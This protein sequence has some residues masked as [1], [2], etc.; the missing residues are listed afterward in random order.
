MQPAG[1]DHDPPDSTWQHE[2]HNGLRFKY[3]SLR[4]RPPCTCALETTAGQQKICVL[5][6]HLRQAIYI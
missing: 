5:A 2:L 6:L 1:P 4:T 3:T